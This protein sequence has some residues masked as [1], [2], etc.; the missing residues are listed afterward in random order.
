M[1]LFD[2][3]HSGDAE[4]GKKSS[5]RKTFEQTVA[6]DGDSREM[7]ALR[8]RQAVRIRVVMDKVFVAGTKA[9]AGYE[10]SRMI[11]IAGGE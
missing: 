2:W 6:L 9:W 1:S 5:A 8:I 7:R 3:V 11:A 10:E 4:A